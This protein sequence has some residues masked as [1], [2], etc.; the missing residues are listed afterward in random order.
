MDG[1]WA[2]GQLIHLD[3]R[4]VAHDKGAISFPTEKNIEKG[5]LTHQATSIEWILICIE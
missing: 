2:D 1:T 4:L 3:L 5:L